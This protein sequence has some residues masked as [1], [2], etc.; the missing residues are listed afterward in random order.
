MVLLRNRDGVLPL[1]PAHIGSLLVTGP[2]ADQVLQGGGS[3]R[4]PAAVRVTPLEGLR[5]A[6]G[7]AVRITHVPWGPLAHAT[8]DVAKQGAKAAAENA[9]QTVPAPT[10]AAKASRRRAA[11]IKAAPAPPL[12]LPALTTAA[13][14]VGAVLFVAAGQAGSEGMDLKDMSLPEDQDEVIDAL[15]KVNP[16]VIVVIVGNGAVCLEPWEGRVPAILAIHYAGQATGQGL[17][18]VLTGKVNPGG[19]LSYTF[20]RHLEDYP[21]HALNEWPA[22]LVLDKDPGSPGIRPEKRRATHAFD[23]EYAEGVFV[24]Y[25]WFDQ[26]GIEPLFPFGFG[27]SYTTFALLDGRVDVRRGSVRDPEAQV[28]I[29]VTNTGRRRGA[30]VVQVY[31]QDVEAS[32]P[33]P[34]RELKGFQKVTLDPGQSQR[35]TIPLDFRSFAFWSPAKKDWVV[36]PGAFRIAIGTSSRAIAQEVEMALR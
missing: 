20:A 7:E 22:R 34:P 28:S 6:L 11:A 25:R 35:V 31:V 26:K 29:R 18:D 32:A 36:E 17:A 30:E 21:C 4:V 2:A 15:A 13:R 27:L 1:D 19:K 14:N 5:E 12:D 8:G 24:G 10:R 3:G 16:R 9:W 33:R 23:T